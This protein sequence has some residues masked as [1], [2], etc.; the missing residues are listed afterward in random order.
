MSALSINM[1]DREKPST[2]TDLKP[3]I[4]PQNKLRLMSYDAWKLASTLADENNPD[5]L[6][7]ERIQKT[8]VE[9]DRMA[10]EDAEC[11]CSPRQDCRECNIK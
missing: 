5:W 3:A 10:D 4:H 8:A 11:K 1:S 2:W 7:I 6:R 9:L